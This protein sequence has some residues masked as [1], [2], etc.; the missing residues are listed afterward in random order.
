MD[1][2]NNSVGS[3]KKASIAAIQEDNV[4]LKTRLIAISDVSYRSDIRLRALEVRLDKLDV[5]VGKLEEKMDTISKAIDYEIDV[6]LMSY[7][8]RLEKLEGV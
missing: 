2:F 7:N 5:S 8:K 4:V 1:I 6:A 3:S